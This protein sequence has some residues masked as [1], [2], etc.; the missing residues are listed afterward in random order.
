M[1]DEKC[2][3]NTYASSSPPL[4]YLY[5]AKMERIPPARHLR[6]SLLVSLLAVVI[7]Y[8]PLPLLKLVLLCVDVLGFW[9]RRFHAMMFN[10]P[11]QQLRAR[12]GSSQSVEEYQEIALELDAMLQ[13]DAW[14]DNLVSSK[15]D[16]RLIHERLKDLREARL[17]DDTHRVMSLLRAG[18]LRNFGGISNKGLFN[19]SFCGTKSLI[20]EY[21]DEVLF[22]LDWICELDDTQVK[23]DFFHDAKTTMGT[24]ALCLHGGSIFGMCHVGVVKAL[25]ECE[26]LPD[27]IAGSGIGA[28][29]GALVCCLSESELEDVLND[30]R[31]V[32]SNEGYSVNQLTMEMITK[33]SNPEQ[34]ISEESFESDDDHRVAKSPSPDIDLDLDWLDDLRRGLSPSL[35]LFIAFVLHKVGDL[36]F[37]EAHKK[38][39]KTLNVLVYPSNQKV[40]N[41]L[42][43]LSTPYVTVKSAICCAMGDIVINGSGVEKI[44]NG[45]NSMMPS[46]ELNAVLE[47]KY[48]DKISKFTELECY[49][50]PPYE[51]G[52]ANVSDVT[53]YTAQGMRSPY[54]RLSEMFNVNH[55]VISISRPYLA[56]LILW[57]W[58]V[59]GQRFNYFNSSTSSYTILPLI[60]GIYKFFHS[61]FQ[62]IWNVIIMEMKHR[63]RMFQKLGVNMGKLGEMMKWIIVDE[64]ESLL[65]TNHVPLV[66]SG[67]RWWVFDLYKIVEETGFL[68]EFKKRGRRQSVSSSTDSVT[69]SRRSS[70]AIIDEN[71]ISTLQYWIQCGERSVWSM[72][73]LLLVRCAIEFRVNEHFNSHQREIT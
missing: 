70:A 64:K 58:K 62:F 7:S 45:L 55:F 38:M 66:P 43:Y 30:L 46:E 41:L 67:E 44:M 34:V 18:M 2:L 54:M 32:M 22:C 57:E 25:F 52:G 26:L 17:N 24:T 53:A 8:T 14:K 42:N 31:N 9:R 65:E 11:R 3:R 69:S 36:T 23:L 35:K 72:K 1:A 4:S 28:V 60:G 39:G 50:N 20:E 21:V 13:N 49:F 71:E 68:S 27:V 37:L 63:F 48:Q 19:K 40:P 61:L 56:P 10:S 51:S 15:Y 47:V 16:Y 6:S 5:L 59:S 33:G 73:T 12:L 29:V